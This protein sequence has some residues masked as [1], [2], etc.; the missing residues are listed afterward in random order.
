V[1]V[2]FSE[3]LDGYRKADSFTKFGVWSD[4]VLAALLVLMLVT[5]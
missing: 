5:D 1:K 2:F 3:V 4:V